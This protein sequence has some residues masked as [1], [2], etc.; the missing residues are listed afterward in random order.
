M[1]RRY[2]GKISFL[3]L[4][5]FKGHDGELVID[6]QTGLSYVMDGNTY[7]G[8]P[9]SLVTTYSQTAPTNP[10]PGTL[11]FNP[12]DKVLNIFDGNIWDNAAQT[13]SNANVASY[14]ISNPITGNIGFNNDIIFD[15]NPEDDTVESFDNIDIEPQD[16]GFV[17]D[18]ITRKAMQM[19]AKNNIMKDPKQARKAER[20]R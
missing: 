15:R 10:T 20:N 11:W 5:Q 1:L 13:Y 17:V 2:Y 14:L 4:N 16:R 19:K 9:L 7:G 3:P 18:D 12:V 6:D 8:H